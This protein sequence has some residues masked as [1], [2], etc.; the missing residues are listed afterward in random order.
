MAPTKK[1]K[2]TKSSENINSRFV[3]FL[4]PPFLLASSLLPI[5]TPYSAPLLLLL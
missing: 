5:L 3:S 4:L 2:A 1:S